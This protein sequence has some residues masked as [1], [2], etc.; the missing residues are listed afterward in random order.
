MIVHMRMKILI[1]KQVEHFKPKKQ[2]VDNYNR[3][4]GVVIDFG[5]TKN[6]FIPVRPTSID[7]KLEIDDEYIIHPFQ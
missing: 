2:I 5:T 6:I 4:I 3:M 7:I 1:Y